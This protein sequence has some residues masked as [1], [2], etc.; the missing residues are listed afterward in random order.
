MDSFPR[1]FL[2]HQRRSAPISARPMSTN[3]TLQLNP[4]SHVRRPLEVPSVSGKPRKRRHP[5][6]CQ[7]G[8]RK[9]SN[10]RATYPPPSRYSSVQPHAAEN[11]GE[12]EKIGSSPKEAN[13][14]KT[15]SPPYPA[16][17]FYQFFLNILPPLPAP[18]QQRSATGK[19]T[20]DIPLFGL[21]DSCWN[22]SPRW[23]LHNKPL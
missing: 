20:F 4:S 6:A 15:N 13:I 10:K 2:S 14:N 18:A 19:K 1:S 23:Q 16:R 11:G 9:R 7:R 22:R 3:F 21:W 8:T 5:D 12:R 17:A